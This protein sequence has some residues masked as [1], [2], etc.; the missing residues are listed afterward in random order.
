MSSAVMKSIIINRREI[1]L[2][3]RHILQ[4]GNPPLRKCEIRI[5]IRI[6]LGFG[7]GIGIGIDQ[8][9]IMVNDCAGEI[10]RYC[11]ISCCRAVWI[12]VC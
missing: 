12:G 7:T 1:L 3:D 10:R 9:P 11:M 5:N 4:K 6:G 2:S 8:K